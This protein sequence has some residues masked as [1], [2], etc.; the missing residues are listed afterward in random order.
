MYLHKIRYNVT[1]KF[2]EKAGVLLELQC[3]EMLKN[4]L[5]FSSFYM[6]SWLPSSPSSSSLRA[7]FCYPK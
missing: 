3:M 5:S 4:H 7:A 1:I 6:C 2:T